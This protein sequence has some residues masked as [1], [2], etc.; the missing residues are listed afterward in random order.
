MST[1][2]TQNASYVSGDGNY[3]SDS[4]IV[5][6]NDLLTEKQWTILDNLGDN[7]RFDYVLA[8]INGDDLSEYELD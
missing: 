8:I 1:Q 4:L 5:F 6:D 2:I 7:S 3:G